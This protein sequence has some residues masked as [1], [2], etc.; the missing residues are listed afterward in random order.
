MNHLTEKGTRPGC[1]DPGIAALAPVKCLDLS[2]CPVQGTLK[3][4]RNLTT[5]SSHLFPGHAKLIQFHFGGVKFTAELQQRVIALFSDGLQD[6]LDGD[7][8]LAPECRPPLFNF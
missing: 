8:V 1:I 2:G 5:G 3:T 7:D 6:T 4:R